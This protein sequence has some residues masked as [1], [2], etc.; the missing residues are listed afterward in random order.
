MSLPSLEN[1]T[2][3]A[4]SDFV[5]L[6]QGTRRNEECQKT[7]AEP[8]DFPVQDILT[9]ELAGS[10]GELLLT[11]AFIMRHKLSMVASDD[12]ITLLKLPYP[13]ENNA[14]KGLGKFKEYFQ[15]LKHPMKKHFCCP[16]LKCQVYIY[17]QP[18]QRMAMFVTYAVSHYQGSHFS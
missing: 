9:E 14:V 12:L 15:Y 3:G 13:A 10:W 7:Y 2:D 17:L 4:F 11:M 5:D 8:C 16:N 18:N 1:N 6:M